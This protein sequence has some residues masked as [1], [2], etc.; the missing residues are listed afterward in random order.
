MQSRGVDSEQNLPTAA[1]P[2]SCGKQLIRRAARQG[3]QCGKKARQAV[4]AERRQS[5]KTILYGAGRYLRLTIQEINAPAV[6]PAAN[7]V[8]TMSMGWRWMR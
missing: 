8:A 6:K 2:Q 5:Q 1:D 4:S 7:V 3:P